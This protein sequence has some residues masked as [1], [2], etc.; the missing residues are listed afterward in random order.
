MEESEFIKQRASLRIELE[1]LK[2]GI[3]ERYTQMVNSYTEKYS[4]LEKL[5]VYEIE[6]KNKRRKFERFV[7]YDLSVSFIGSHP[8]ITAGG[9][10]LNNES[11]PTKWDN[12]TV[13][14]I[15]NPEIFVL[16][17]DQTANPHPDSDKALPNED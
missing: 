6:K 13:H 7:V 17:E 11:I 2:K 12:F 10:W 9:W 3:D 8:I 14:N 5:K 4:P 1:F 16:S 15:S